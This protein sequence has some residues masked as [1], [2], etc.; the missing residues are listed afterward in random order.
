MHLRELEL[1]EFRSY[2]HL[3]LPLDP[4]GLRLWGANASGKSS[5]LEAIA[6][7]A[8][9]R[10]PR[11]GNERELLNWASGADLGFPPF[12]RLRGIVRRADGDAEIEIALQA[13]LTRPG[14][15]RKQIKLNGR[16]VRAMD[17]V[18][19]LRAVLFSPD[20][21]ALVAGPPAG[22]RRYLDLTIS[23]LDGAYL[24]AL[25]RYARVLSQRNS[26]LKALARD[27]VAPD[28]SGASS[29]LA[30]WDEEL[31]A[32]GSVIIARRFAFSR[33]LGELSAERFHLLTQAEGFALHYQ[34]TFPLASLATN[35]TAGGVD[36]AQAVVAREYGARLRAARSEELRRG[37]SLV[38]P[39][40][41]DLAFEVGGVDLAVY[42]SRG[43]QRLAVV[44]LK[45]AETA[46][47]TEVGGEAPVL[48][49]DDV[50][51]ELDAA[52]RALVTR[53]AAA[54]NAQLLV[55][56]TDPAA[57]DRPDLAAIPRARIE[58]GSVHF[59]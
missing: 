56:A 21:V 11:G 27:R 50:L 28:S 46:L 22:R 33:R 55:T 16:A 19:T 40:R 44:A 24:R 58:S 39:H 17:A 47:M 4:R 34:P 32:L 31:V 13:D 7:L 36:A 54:V 43:Q 6:M 15:L 20:D 42:G 48:L 18:G 2:R 9:T 59:E 52:H 57:L 14:L 12:A 26:L 37:A 45:L 35:G 3:H 38:G 1:E 53:T 51:S 41:D 25:S 49:L 23:Q 29:Q 10:S 5:L 8:T 30:F